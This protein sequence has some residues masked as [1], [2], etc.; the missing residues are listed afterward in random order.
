M[1]KF[2][3]TSNIKKFVEHYI[4]C[5]RSMFKGKIVIDIPAGKGETSRILK[6]IGSDIRSYDLFPE[7]YEY[8][9]LTCMKANLAKE[10]P[11]E[12]NSADI[13]ICQEGIEHVP[14]QLLVLQEFNRILKK[15]G[16]LILTTPNISHLRAKL[17]YLFTESELFKRMPPNELDSLWYEK[18]GRR[19][20]GHVFLVGIQKLRVLAATAGFRIK[21]INPVKL[22][23]TSVLLSFLYPMVVLV[24]LYVYF[25]NMAKKDGIDR[26]TK[27]AVY[28]D[29][30]KLNINPT[31]QFGRHLF[32]V[33]EKVDTLLG[34]HRPRRQIPD[35]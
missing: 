14:N 35:K 32:L 10:L 19:Y 12:D 1:L 33:L 22:S 21:K 5:N 23:V 16:I 11:I 20:F 6:N 26:E 13:I 2:T 31:I 30:I 9:K 18:D 15:E 34:V 28:L 3:G 29:I 7:F 25:I 27:K 24:N 8:D 17:S 4:E